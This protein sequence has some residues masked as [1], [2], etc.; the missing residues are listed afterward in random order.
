MQTA[1]KRARASPGMR[2]GLEQG[3]R[4]VWTFPPVVLRGKE[5]TRR[6]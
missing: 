2:H 3:L 6:G 5:R 1:F 4:D